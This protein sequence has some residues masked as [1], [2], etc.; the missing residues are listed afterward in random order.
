MGPG[1]APVVFTMAPAPADGLP[2]SPPA[3]R[4]WPSLPDV[5]GQKK[6]EGGVG[7]SFEGWWPHTR[8]TS[9]PPIGLSSTSS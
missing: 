6:V 5:T 4:T 1:A 8:R 3:P 2:A 9:H 7:E